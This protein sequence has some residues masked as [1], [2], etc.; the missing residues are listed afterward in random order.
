MK[1]SIS[2]PGDLEVVIYVLPGDEPDER[3]YLIPLFR[4]QMVLAIHPDHRL[5][6]ATAFPVW[7][8]FFRRPLQGVELRPPALYF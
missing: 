5:A 3:T 6:K 4:E 2:S 1:S 8:M 7:R